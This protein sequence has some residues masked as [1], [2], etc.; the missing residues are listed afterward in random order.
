VK[1]I[2]RRYS[3]EIVKG[4]YYEPLP[5][6]VVC[7]VSGLSEGEVV[8]VVLTALGETPELFGAGR[9]FTLVGLI[10]TK[11]SHGEALDALSFGFD[12]FEPVTE[13]KDGDGPWSAALAPPSDIEAALA[14]YVWAGLAAPRGRLRWEAAH[15]VRGLC[16]LRREK[17]LGFLVA[18]ATAS[19]GGPF[20]DARLHFYDMHAR[21]WLLIALARAAKEN[22]E[23]LFPH[24]DFLIRLALNGE[25]HILIR[26]FA[27]RAALELMDSGVPGY[28]QPDLREKLLAVN[29]SPFPVAESKRY[30]RIRPRDGGAGEEGER[31]D[32]HFGL[33]IGP[34]LLAPLGEWFARSQTE[35]EREVSNVITKEWRF[36][37]RD[38]WIEDAR[39]RLKI[40]RDG[41]T[42]ESRSLN[43]RTHD[44]DFYLAYH[45]MMVVAG[46]LLGRNPV[47]HD[48]DYP[49]DGFNTWVSNHGLTRTD[50]GWLADRRDPDPLERPRWADDKRTDDWRWSLCRDDFDALL[51][52]PG[53]RLNLW[54]HWTRVEG[55]REESVA[56]ES[57]L[58]SEGRSEALL[59]ALQCSG[60]H[61]YVIPGVDDDQIDAGPFQLRAWVKNSQRSARLDGQ[62][63]W[64]GSIVYPPIAPAHFVVDVLHLRSDLEQCSWWM[65][66]G[67]RDEI[68][69]WCQVWGQRRERDDD[70]DPETGRRFQGSLAFVRELLR[71]ARKD[72]IIKV[73]I[74]RRLRHSRHHRES[75]DEFG[76]AQPSARLF[77][78]KP[79]GTIYSV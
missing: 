44:L 37:P 34:Y 1:A 76:Y 45:A 23:V 39:V 71:S 48:P 51:F 13:A 62:D 52:L 65:R 61:D 58:V 20:V 56:I 12:L 75:S 5:L 43:P 74:G 17:V 63:P 33:D 36:L 53:E 54:G 19:K 14:G 2:C 30:E 4:G 16:T 40:F 24:A 70:E 11:L 8:D 79:D 64:A 59:R 26:G 28:D 42:Y 66:N 22:P 9:L 21:Q 35:V 25:P 7:E 78:V 3:I 27:A 77:L 41:E 15:V 18:L 50:G 31:P 73:E 6:R 32:L 57:A 10:A 60:S 69:L 72:L 46:R 67:E 49:E 55:N 68:A 29:K 38:R 47:H